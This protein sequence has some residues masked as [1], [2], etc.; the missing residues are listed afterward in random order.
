LA[1]AAAFL[2]SLPLRISGL[3]LRLDEAP[4]NPSD[5]PAKG[6]AKNQAYAD[7]KRNAAP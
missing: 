6:M 3:W 2:P 7:E 1:V 5:N 4:D